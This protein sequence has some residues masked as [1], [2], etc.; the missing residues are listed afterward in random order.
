MKT[1]PLFIAIC[2]LAVLAA[3]A[4]WLTSRDSAKPRAERLS[5]ETFVEP[6]IVENA[7]EIHLLG[8]SDETVVLRQED[9]RW[10]LPEYFGLPADFDKLRRMTGSLLEAKIERFVTSNPD[11]LERLK[12]GQSAVR[13]VGANG[14]E[15]TLETGDRGSS[16]GTFFKIN[17]EDSAY[18]TTSSLYLDTRESNWPV[19]RPIE[20]E[21]GDVARVEL[22][23]DGEPL[24]FVREKKGDPYQLD[25]GKENETAKSS[26]VASLV[27]TLVTARFTEA[28]EPDGADVQAAREH[29]AA[30]T[31]A[32]FDGANYTLHVGRRPG[33]EAEE[34]DAELEPEAKGAEKSDSAK[35]SASVVIDQDGNIVSPEEI[36]AAEKAAKDKAAAE[37]ADTETEAASEANEEDSAPEPV[38]IEPGPVFIFYESD[39]PDFIWA[40]LMDRVALKYSDYLYNQLPD[41][42]ADLIE[43]TAPV[44]TTASEE[45]RESDET[46]DATDESADAEKTESPS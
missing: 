46:T 13:F 18:L 17:G 22:T 44:E 3:L 42:R 33:S 9:G 12:L 8:D 37:S 36:A 31:I 20:L 45:T 26:D 11:S 32:S 30:F 25:G 27:R 29:A 43:V 24:V 14:D 1:K 34:A 35:V 41:S 6:A 15:W 28:L 23:L 38:D 16:G 5:G 21:E 40:S 7:R 10:I 39:D 19:K 2:L 4:S